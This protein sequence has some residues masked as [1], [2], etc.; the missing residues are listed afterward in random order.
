MT[1]RGDEA[2]TAVTELLDRM[3]RAEAE[4]I[5]VPRDGLGEAIEL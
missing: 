2:M 5:G 4:I 1:T 3:R